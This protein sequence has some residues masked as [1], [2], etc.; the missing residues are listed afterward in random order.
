MFGVFEGLKNP[1]LQQ[2]GPR[3]SVAFCLFPTLPASMLL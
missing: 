2:Y 1:G 3:V